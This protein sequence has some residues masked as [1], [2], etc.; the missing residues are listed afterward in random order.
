MIQNKIK[1]G[2]KTQIIKENIHRNYDERDQISNNTE[3][4]AYEIEK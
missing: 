3:R 2:K 4:Q 1:Q